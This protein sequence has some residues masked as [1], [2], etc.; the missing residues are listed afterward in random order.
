MAPRLIEACGCPFRLLGSLASLSSLPAL[1]ARVAWP[2]PE[3][4]LRPC[5][6]PL[7]SPCRLLE[8]STLQTR[9]Q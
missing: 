5:L 7:A 3:P 8:R 1:L 6:P 2:L 4:C 9:L